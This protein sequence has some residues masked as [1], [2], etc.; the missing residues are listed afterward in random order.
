[1]KAYQVVENGR[2]LEKKEMDTPNPT[3]KEI[4]LKTVSCGVCHS[5]VHIHDGYFDLGGDMKLPLPLAEPL[6]MG[7]EIFGEVVAIGDEVTID[8]YWRKICCLSMDWLWRLRIM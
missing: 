6:T 3:G 2:P 8:K 7:H 4:L 1:M 5:D